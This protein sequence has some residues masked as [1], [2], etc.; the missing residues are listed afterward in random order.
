MRSANETDS[1]DV[2]RVA[3]WLVAVICFGPS[4]LTWLL[5]VLL[6]PFWIGM[7]FALLEQ[8]EGFAHD[9][10]AN[11]WVLALPIGLVLGGFIGLIGVVR[12]LTLSRRE[13]PK[14]HRIFTIGM[15]A[16]GLTAVL[17]FDFPRFAGD[18]SDFVDGRNVAAFL[19]YFGLPF[20][21]AAWLLAKSWRFLV[22]GSA[23]SDVESRRSR[24]KHESRDDWRLD[25]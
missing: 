10:S 15:V 1:D 18:S 19:V 6:L 5:G 12:V 7:L 2:P 8:P 21:G 20:G 24:I 9:P 25:A 4:V 16:I 23:G 13:R 11:V 22:A 14:S 3:L 17:S